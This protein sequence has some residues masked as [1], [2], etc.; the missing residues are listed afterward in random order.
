MVY[1]NRIRMADHNVDVLS[2]SYGT[3][4]AKLRIWQCD[5]IH[6]YKKA[7]LSHN[8]TRLKKVEN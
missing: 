3:E 8:K 7:K 1:R 5:A 6:K 2:G 4:L